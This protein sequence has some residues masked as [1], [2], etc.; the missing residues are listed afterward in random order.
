M[1]KRGSLTI[2][3][4]VI[5]ILMALYEFI[6]YIIEI[7]P[8]E[9]LL[10]ISSTIFLFLLVMWVVEDGRSKTN[11]YKPYDFGFLI[12]M[13]WL[14]YMPYYFLKTRGLIGLVYLVGLLFLLNMGLL[15]QW[16]HYYAT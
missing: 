11:I 1:S 7:Y 2:G 13:F 12:L 8:N 16:G 5:S 6:A 3:L 4:V 15:L 9:Y 14:P 10:K